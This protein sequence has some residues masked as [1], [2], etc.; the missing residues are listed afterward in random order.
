MSSGIV[1]TWRKPLL[2]SDAAMSCA[3]DDTARNCLVAAEYHR[4]SQTG[5]QTFDLLLKPKG[6]RAGNVKL[7]TWFGVHC[8]RIEF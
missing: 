8:L 7:C 2:R 4:Q 6:F 3:I 1:C 5:L